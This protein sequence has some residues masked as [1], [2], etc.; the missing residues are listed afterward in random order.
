[1]TE[2]N[3]KVQWKTD[4]S[5]FP[6]L[7]FRSVRF[8]AYLR[9]FVSGDLD[10]Y[11]LPTHC[12]CRHLAQLPTAV[13]A[14]PH[15]L[16]RAAVR[17]CEQSK[18]EKKESKRVLA[19]QSRHPKS[20]CSHFPSYMLIKRQQRQKLSKS[21]C[22]QSTTQNTRRWLQSL[23]DN[24]IWLQSFFEC[25]LIVENTFKFSISRQFSKTVFVSC[26]QNA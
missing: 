11:C 7:L 24:F 23:Y 16:A 18:N 2:K 6:Q 4:L 1:M 20:D 26:S 15:I 12:G 14:K 21:D 10:D 22:T 5:P 19:F 8:S 17:K 25:S 13:R 9:G 3:A